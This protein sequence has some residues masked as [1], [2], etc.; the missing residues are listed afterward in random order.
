MHISTR[1]EPAVLEA[2][3][4]TF[5]SFYPIHVHEIIDI[6]MLNVKAYR[7]PIQ[8]PITLGPYSYVAAMSYIALRYYQKAIN[9][10]QT[11]ALRIPGLT[12]LDSFGSNPAILFRTLDLGIVPTVILYRNDCSAI[13]PDL[14]HYNL[15]ICFYS[16][17]QKYARNNITNINGEFD[18]LT[19]PSY[20]V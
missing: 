7:Y 2:V 8:Q 5:C 11:Q 6:V 16:I 10:I 1:K 20:F 9:L 3:G 13:L 15:E 4:T 18:Y 17:S 12:R 14:M 19:N